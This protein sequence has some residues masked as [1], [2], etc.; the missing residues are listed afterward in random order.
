MAYNEEEIRPMVTEAAKNSKSMRAAS[1][2]TPMN[3]KTFLKYAKKFDV[4]EPNKAGKNIEKPRSDRF[5]TEDILD[6]EHQGYNSHKL[7]KRLLKEGFKKHQCEKCGR[8]SWQG[9]KI[10]L[11][12]HHING[13]PGDH[14]SENI[15]LLCPNCHS[16]TDT[17]RGKNK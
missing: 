11:E 2:K 4:F 6:G 12:I 1:R 16:L 13:D 3:Y 17:Y 15:Q 9:Q 8:S 5:D 10:P 14:H 7:K